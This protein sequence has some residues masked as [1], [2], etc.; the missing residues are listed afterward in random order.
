MS[1]AGPKRPRRRVP[2]PAAAAL[3]AAREQPQRRGRAKPSDPPGAAGLVIDVQWA[4]I[5]RADGDVFVVGHYVGVLPQNAEL[6]LDIALSGTKEPSRL[7]L[8]DLTRRGAIR[9][10]LGDVI[11]FPLPDGKQIV[12]AGMGR[13]G[14][15]GEA[16]LKTLARSVTETLGRLMK[17]PTVCTVLIGSG[18]GNLQV[19]ESVTGLLAG[20]GEA[21]AADPTLEVGRLRIVERNLD[22]AYEILGTLM[23]TAERFSKE[24]GLKV[25]VVP[26][27][28][29]RDAAGGVIPIPFGF[30][31]MLAS[32]AQACFEGKG[33]RLHATAEA[34]VA[35]LPEHLRDEVRKDLQK[36]GSERNLRRLG[37]KFK[38]GQE[39][40]PRAGEISDRISFSQDGTIVRTAAITNMTTV[41][42][43]ALGMQFAW[44]DRIV[45]DL[46]AALPDGVEERSVKAFNHLIHPDLR[47]KIL[48]EGPLVIEVDRTLARVPWEMI[49]DS[50]PGRLPL[51]VHRPLARQLRTTYSPRIA[52]PVSPDRLKALVIGDPDDT[53]EY[54]RAEAK[55]VAEILG[56]RG[57]DVVLR[58]GPPDEL[59]LGKY[60][61]DP[62]DLFDIIALLQSGDFDLVHYSGHAM[63]NAEYPD[64]SG[65][66]FDNR[67]VFTPSKLENVDRPPRLIVANA[68]IS[69]ALSPGAAAAPTPAANAPRAH[70]PGDAR[71]VA[72]LADEFFRRGVA[73]YIGTAWEVPELP[74][75]MFAEK[76]YQA[77]LGNKPAGRRGNGGATLGHAVQEAR[78]ALYEQRGKWGELGTV[79]G[80]YQHYGD[81]T[82]TLRE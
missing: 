31:L 46:H 30:S 80:A 19:Q 40:L 20:I 38:L 9:G 64:Q 26:D 48:S 23:D 24:H 58:L 56:R 22:K 15:F 14:L 2:A 49:H 18:F 74:A 43:R 75:K 6:A 72:S 51:A 12:L 28:V 73:D 81:P 44:I 76:F 29:E 5:V 8:T 16:Q 27:V 42:E 10:A 3:R 35:E 4:D 62:A 60:G 39:D 66:A 63:F 82:R 54:A 7:V 79:W 61:A 11:F 50:S 36:R 52:D 32:L 21:L 41:T 25:K 68:C 45:D 57:I 53:L 59:R 34:L 70:R 17:R 78:K 55:A 47:D 69:A 65:W 1:S 13:P 33:S 37:L 77:L 71:I 67:E